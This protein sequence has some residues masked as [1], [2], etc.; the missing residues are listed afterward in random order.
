MAGTE[1]L[2]LIQPK[3][4]PKMS[5]IYAALEE[6]WPNA[7]INSYE[8]DRF[9]LWGLIGNN[10]MYMINPYIFCDMPYNG[11]YD[12]NN[13]DWDNTYWRWCYDGL[14]DNRKL[15]VP[16]DRFEQWGRKV[17]PWKNDG[18]YILICPSSETMTKTMHG[19]SVASWVEMVQK[20]V[21]T[22]T[23]LPTKVRLK[24]RKNGTSGPSV[25]ENPI[26]DDLAGA[27]AMITAGS[28]TAVDALLEGVPVFTTKPEVCPAAWC[29]NTDFSRLN[30]PALFDR[31]SLFA[32]L[33]YKQYSIEEMRN[34]TC[35]EMSL[36]FLDNKVK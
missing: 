8:Y 36:R 9:V 15:D 16:I 18:D 22:Y 7:K 34:G 32:N 19:M 2:S 10:L 6:G 21:L 29:S 14:H 28:L 13:E 1:K 31:E 24:P 30:T 33:A 11:R 23:N 17:K 25:A 5:R 26:E 35:Y 27:K 20:E 4:S 3:D 12:P